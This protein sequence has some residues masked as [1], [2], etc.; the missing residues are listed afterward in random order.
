MNRIVNAGQFAAWNGDSGR[1][2]ADDPDRRD[3]VLAPVA[4]ALFGAVGLRP[5]ESVIDIGCGCGATTLIAAHAV[6]GAGSAY[7][8]DLS[9][10]MLDVARR[11]AHER[12]IT[13][14]RF[15][16]GDVQALRFPTAVF[17]VAL[18]R[19]GTM[20]FADQV[21]AFTNVARALR[22]GGRMCLTTWQPMVANEWLTVP[23]AVLLRYGSL[24]T[25]NEGPGMF[26]QSDPDELIRVLTAAGFDAAQPRPVAISLHL[27]ADA[28]GAVAYLAGSGPG[29]TIL[30]TIPP[31]LR[32]TAISA[33]QATLEER[34]G[35]HGVELGAAVWVT[36][37]RWA[38]AGKGA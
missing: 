23:G 12:H 25:A 34:L 30:K 1:R 5:G 18:S 17:D 36:E 27:G 16:Q 11:R 15:E 33:V 26:A 37:A 3:Q 14:I 32:P 6:G 10:P 35:P 8:I 19:F 24:P 9:D 2:W 21:A 13:N 31:D 28:A 4:E 29:Q 22:P 20:F 7:G 38:P